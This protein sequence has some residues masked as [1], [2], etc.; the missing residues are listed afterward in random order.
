MKPAIAQSERDFDEYKAAWAFERSQLEQRA[1]MLQ[2]DHDRI[3]AQLRES[4][5]QMCALLAATGVA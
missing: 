1:V 2:E 4:D 5:Q 3:A